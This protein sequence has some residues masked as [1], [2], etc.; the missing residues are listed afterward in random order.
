M[1][2]FTATTA[3]NQFG[4][5]LEA[6]AER[7]V[8]VTRHG[9]VVAYVAAPKD[10]AAP[11]QSLEERLAGRLRAAGV[12]Y[13][14]LFGS[15]ARGAARRES[16]I[17]IAVS[18]GKPMSSDLREALIGIIADVAGR[19]VDL[20]DLEAAQGLVFMRAM[21]GK[22]I[23]CDSVATRQRLI[24]RLQRFEDDGRNVAIAAKAARRALFA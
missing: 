2:K 16:D 14:A 5:V 18:F 17:D 13:A 20:V 10:F 6:A 15:L 7:P 9:R 12:R 19:A 3:K 8:A 23:V 4:R 22:E 11:P 24:Q 1:R 21:Q